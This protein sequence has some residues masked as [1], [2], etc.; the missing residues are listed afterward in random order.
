MCVRYA[1]VN[2]AER[3]RMMRNKKYRLLSVEHKMQ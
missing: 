2:E 3:L 1:T